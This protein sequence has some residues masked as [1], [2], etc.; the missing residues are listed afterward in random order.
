MVPP[1]DRARGRSP[2]PHLLRAPDKSPSSLVPSGGRGGAH[3]ASAHPWD[4]GRIRWDY[5][6]RGPSV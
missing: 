2:E 4:R 5:A 6:C 1:E 3:D